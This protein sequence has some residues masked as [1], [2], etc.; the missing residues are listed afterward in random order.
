MREAGASEEKTHRDS[1]ERRTA[2]ERQRAQ[3]A[4][5]ALRAL[6]AR[7]RRCDDRGNSGDAE[8]GPLVRKPVVDCSIASAWVMAAVLRLAG[9][10]APAGRGR[11]AP[12][13]SGCSDGGPFRLIPAHSGCLA[14]A[15]RCGTLHRRERCGIP[16]RR[17]LTG[18]E[19]G[20]A[21]WMEREL[22]RPRLQS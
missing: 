15:C 3:E 5:E 20:G 18:R 13:G 7:V 21:P 16:L 9:N 12:A 8:R 19:Q 1:G 4:A 10:A 2:A 17:L 14:R 6:R 22:W 11:L